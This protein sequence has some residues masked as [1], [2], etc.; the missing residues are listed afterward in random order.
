MGRQVN[1]KTNKPFLFNFFLNLIS[2]STPQAIV[3]NISLIFLI[4]AFVPTTNLETVGIPCIYKEVILPFIYKN[5]CPTQG[6]FANCE[7]P[8]CGMTRAM[9][10]ML[11]GKFKEAIS[12]NK[13]ILILL[14]LMIFILIQN[15]FKWK[16]H[17]I[18]N[19][20]YF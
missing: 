3:I 18:K 12:Y 15:I 2:F 17:Y 7:C 14:P 5:N 13:G 9:S 20:T 16:N 10:S 6:L 11:H 19:K 4:L 1:K 8:A